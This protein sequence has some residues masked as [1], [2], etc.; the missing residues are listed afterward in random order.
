MHIYH[1]FHSLYYHQTL[2]SDVLSTRVSQTALISG[3]RF[4]RSVVLVDIHT[5][6]ASI[7]EGRMPQLIVFDLECVN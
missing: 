1:P 3:G 5:M 2:G 7:F 4:P 6:V